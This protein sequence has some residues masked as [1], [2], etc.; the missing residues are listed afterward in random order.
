MIGGAQGSGVDTPASIFAKAV[1]TAGFHVYGTREYYSNIK[2][3]HSYFQ[4]RFG[5]RS[6]RSHVDSVDLLATFD[7]ETVARHASEVRRDGAIVFDKDVVGNKNRGH[8]HD[9]AERHEPA[10]VGAGRARP[11]PY[12]RRRL[13]RREE[14]GRP[15]LPDP[16]H[17]HTQ[18]PCRQ[19]R[20]DPVELPD[21][22]DQCDVCGGL[23][24]P[25]RLPQGSA[26]RG[27]PQAVQVQAQGRRGERRRRGRHLRIRD[28]E[29]RGELPHQA[30]GA[31]T[32][33]EETHARQREHGRGDSQDRR[34]LQAPD[35]LPHHPCQR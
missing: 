32:E 31:R 34:G 23:L 11:P 16:L 30:G 18:F 12:H 10:E 19:A 27:D 6:L 3:E 2:G 20:G 5:P 22:H 4:V 8:P 29:L 25:A 15:P 26:R 21:A 28:Q 7:D 1:A 9:R 24:R 33:R 13:G 35:L 14:E 17:G